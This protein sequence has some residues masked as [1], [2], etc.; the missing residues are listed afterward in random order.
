MRKIIRYVPI[1]SILLLAGCGG[2]K[3]TRLSNFSSGVIRA[4][5]SKAHARLSIR[6]LDVCERHL[7]EAAYHDIT[8]TIKALVAEDVVDINACNKFGETALHQAALSGSANVVTTLLAAGA[9]PNIARKDGRT[10]LYCAIEQASANDT[11]IVELLLKAGAA[12]NSKTADTVTPLHIAITQENPAAVHMLLQ[13][14][15]D[16]NQTSTQITPGLHNEMRSHYYFKTVLDHLKI[17]SRKLPSPSLTPLHLAMLLKPSETADTIVKLLIEANADIHASAGGP[18]NFTP[19]H[20]AA[21]TGNAACAKIVCTATDNPNMNAA[22]HLTPLHVAAAYGHT[23]VAQTLLAGGANPNAIDTVTQTTPLMV[24]VDSMQTLVN[25][26][27]KLQSELSARTK[28]KKKSNPKHNDT[29]SYL[30]QMEQTAQVLLEWPHTNLFVRNSDNQTAYDIAKATVE[31]LDDHISAQKQSRAI[32]ASGLEYLASCVAEEE[33]R[34][35]RR[36]ARHTLDIIKMAM[37]QR[38]AVVTA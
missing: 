14:G 9:N 19:L 2:K 36:R 23:E 21:C 24:A 20:L 28:A 3:C 1:I 22:A 33:L 32:G 38:S 34:S 11:C 17:K 15:A 10:A 12:V 25:S 29:T 6:G 30:A 16:P 26:G 7:F 27:A 31:R 35:N 5:K 18:F 37:R 4:Q 8:G 13:H